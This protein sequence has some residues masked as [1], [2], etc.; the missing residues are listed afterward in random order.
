MGATKTGAPDHKYAQRC[1]QSPMFRITKHVDNP[2]ANKPYLNHMLRYAPFDGHA[3]ISDHFINSV[4]RK[5]ATDDDD[6]DIL[7]S[8]LV[9]AQYG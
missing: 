8:E 5:F 3:Y 6:E 7:L 9:P 1:G 2:K 4:A